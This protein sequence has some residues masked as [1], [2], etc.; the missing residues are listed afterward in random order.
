MDNAQLIVGYHIVLDYYH[1]VWKTHAAH[2]FA[3]APRIID[4]TCQG[5][6]TSALKHWYLVISMLFFRPPD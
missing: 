4:L 5:Q 2:L 1:I 3:G 6:F